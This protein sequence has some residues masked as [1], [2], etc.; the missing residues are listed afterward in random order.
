VLAGPR[1][2]DGRVQRQQVRL[3]R[4]VVDGLDHRADAVAKSP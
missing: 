3:L 4:D 2:L 1:R